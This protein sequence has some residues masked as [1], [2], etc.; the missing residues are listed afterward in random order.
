MQPHAGKCLCFTPRINHWV[1]FREWIEWCYWMVWNKGCIFWRHFCFFILNWL[2]CACDITRVCIVQGVCWIGCVLFRLTVCM[3]EWMLMAGGKFH[4][5]G[6]SAA[7]NQLNQETFDDHDGWC[8]WVCIKKKVPPNRMGYQSLHNG[9]S[10]G[11]AAFSDIPK[12][13][14]CLF[15]KSY[16]LPVHT[17]HVLAHKNIHLNTGS[18]IKPQINKQHSDHEQRRMTGTC[19]FFIAKKHVTNL[20]KM[21]WMGPNPELGRI[22]KRHELHVAF[23]F[24]NW[25][26]VFFSVCMQKYCWIWS[27]RNG[28]IVFFTCFYFRH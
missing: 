10:Y 24:P 25:N 26:G 13:L 6:S 7:N 16:A 27:I 12:R 15:L 22:A 17:C 19:C 5:R 4:S 2:A 28:G 14:A 1:G 3:W 11:H 8:T 20:E 23:Q 21:P 9:P 18:N